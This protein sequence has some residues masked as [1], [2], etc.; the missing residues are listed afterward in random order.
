M[1]Y[2]SA[3]IFKSRLFP[4]SVIIVLVLIKATFAFKGARS[5][6][7]EYFYNYSLFF[8]DSIRNGVWKDAIYNLYNTGRP[9]AN[10]FYLIPSV[11]QAVL[12]QVAGID[13][14]EPPSLI[15]PIIFN[16]LVH[17]GLMLTFFYLIKSIFKVKWM[18]FGGLIIY[19]SLVNNNIYIRHL[20]PYDLSLWLFLTALL[21]LVRLISAKNPD[22]IWGN[23]ILFLSGAF[24]AASFLSYPGFYNGIIPVGLLTLFYCYQHSRYKIKNTAINLSSLG[25]GYLLP[26][27]SFELLAKTGQY[28]YFAKLSNLSGTI[29]QGD[30]DEGFVFPFNYLFS[31]E[32][33]PGLILISGF[34]LYLLSYKKSLKILPVNILCVSLLLIY[35]YHAWS[36]FFGQKMVFYGRLLHI[37]FPFL[38]IGFLAFV[39]LFS[40]KIA[41]LILAICSLIS[42]LTFIRFYVD[43]QKI[44]YPPDV[45]WSLVQQQ[46]CTGQLS[47]TDEIETSSGF[48]P[49]NSTKHLNSSSCDEE[50]TIINCSFFH[51]VKRRKEAPQSPENQNF[52]FSKLHFQLFPAY[53]YEGMTLRERAILNNLKPRISIYRNRD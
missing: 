4:V 22:K 7:D 23:K 2:L 38:V 9:L 5:F 24:T 13:P 41:I 35:L 19:A 47:M 15:F 45:L 31:V 52:M 26:L 27:I 46:G 21:L 43:Y 48:T 28:N 34:I 44:A 25:A 50:W 3:D 33:L 10:I 42:A 11:C 39:H 6:P 20:F 8:L 18:A 36:S 17:G 1:G 16:L 40:R 29:I 53:Q 14:R 12:Y 32:G 49:V 51:P 37:Y 30:F